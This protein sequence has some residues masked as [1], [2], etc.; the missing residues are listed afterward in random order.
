MKFKLIKE[1]NNEF[2]ADAIAIYLNDVKVGYVANSIR[3]ACSL[4]SEAKDIQIQNIA[5]AEYMFYFAY[6][7]HI[8]KILE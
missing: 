6:Q 7:Y 1:D 2:D 8:A 5:Y 4:T 3:T